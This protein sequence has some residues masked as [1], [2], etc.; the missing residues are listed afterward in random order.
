MIPFLR[1]GDPF[2]AFPPLEL[3]LTEPDGLLCAGGDL[4][5]GRLLAAY[6][7]GIFPWYSD[8][9][10]ILWWSPDPRCVLFPD[11]FRVRRSLAKVIRNGGFE[12]RCDT[13]FADVI[14]RCADSGDRAGSTWISPEM[15]S[16]YLGLHQQGYA[17][18]VEAWRD[19]RLVGG[20]Y[21]VAIG[22]AFFGESM[23][24]LERDASKVALARLVGDAL[25][26]RPLDFIDCQVSS[27]HL[28]SLGARPIPRTEFAVRVAQ[29]V[30]AGTPTG[31]WR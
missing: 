31:P 27:G 21:G 2:D 29:A 9:Q 28:E 8:G 14:A 5:P 30:A 24:S 4:A 23:F 25:G 18:S 16:A 6:R 7:R 1:P 12:V 15:R 17:H 19:G 22:R 26:A 11:E 10:P 3:A 20:L 13:A